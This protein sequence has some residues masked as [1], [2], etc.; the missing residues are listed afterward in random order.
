MLCPYCNVQYTPEEPCFCHPRT[1][2]LGAGPDQVR[3]AQRQS[4]D[5]ATS[6]ETS[7]HAVEVFCAEPQR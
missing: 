5:L 6:W 1:I 3:S 4:E 7:P 2:T